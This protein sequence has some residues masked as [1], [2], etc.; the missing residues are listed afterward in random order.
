MIGLVRATDSVKE[1]FVDHFSELD[2]NRMVHGSIDKLMEAMEPFPDDDSKRYGCLIQ[3]MRMEHGPAEPFSQHIWQYYYAG[4]LFIRLKE[5]DD[6]E[7][8]MLAVTEKLSN[9]FKANPRGL[10]QDMA[11]ASWAAD[12]RP[13]DPP[14]AASS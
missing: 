5:V 11:L 14:L 9:T 7:D 10:A 4:I 12:R 1:T 13:E 2:V 3:F 6:I 8:E